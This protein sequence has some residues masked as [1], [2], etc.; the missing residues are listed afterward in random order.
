MAN[1]IPPKRGEEL[2]PEGKPTIRFSEY[3]ERLTGQTNDNTNALNVALVKSVLA[4]VFDIDRRLGSGD[5]LTSD[6][7]GFT[8]DSD[9][10][11]AD[12]DEA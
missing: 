11:F 9:T 10:L 3:L 8:V 2:T 5:A 7:T 1:I 6:T 12:M 4:L